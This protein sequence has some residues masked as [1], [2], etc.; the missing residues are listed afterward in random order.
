VNWASN[1]AAL[2][3]FMRFGYVMYTVAIVCAVFSIMGNF[4][5]SRLAIKK[6]VKVVR[7]V[8]LVVTALLFVK[9]AVDYFAH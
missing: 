1:L 6:D 7:P 8:M 3:N 5:G 9:L 2:I 4:I